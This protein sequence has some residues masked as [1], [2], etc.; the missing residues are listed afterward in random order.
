MT[1]LIKT[2]LSSFQNVH[3]VGWEILVNMKFSR[4]WTHTANIRNNHC[5]TLRVC[6][7]KFTLRIILLIHFN[8]AFGDIFDSKNLLPYG[9]AKPHNFCN[10][11]VR[12]AQYVVIYN[13]VTCF[14]LTEV[15]VIVLVEV[16]VGLIAIISGFG[17]RHTYIVSSGNCT[18]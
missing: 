1:K 18:A 11:D 2:S 13:S 8:G 12:E 3:T 17:Y 6:R 10:H 16:A 7:R 4:H 9:T 5:Y 14:L 15:T